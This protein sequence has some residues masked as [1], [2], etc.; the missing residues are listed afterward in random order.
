MPDVSIPIH[1]TVVEGRLYLQKY[2]NAVELNSSLSGTSTRNSLHSSSAY[3]RH[4]LEKKSTTQT[5]F[6]CSVLQRASYVCFCG[7]QPNT[8]LRCEITDTQGD[9]DVIFFH[10]YAS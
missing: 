3:S 2:P 8:I 9:S 1:Q 5:P 6:Q 10:I 4:S 7:P